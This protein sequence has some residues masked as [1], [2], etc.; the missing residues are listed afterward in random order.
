MK[1][2]Y[3]LLIALGFIISFGFF[4]FELALPNN[5]TSKTHNIFISQGIGGSTTSG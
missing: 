2:R 4:M 3:I 5:S 1:L